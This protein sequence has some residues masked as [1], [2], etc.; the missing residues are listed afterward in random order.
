V[1]TV[2]SDGTLAQLTLRRLVGSTADGQV[3]AGELSMPEGFQLPVQAAV[4]PPRAA[5]RP[6]ALGRF[7]Q[8]ARS[9]AALG[10]LAHPSFVNVFRAGDHL[11]VASEDLP[12]VSLDQVIDR[13]PLRALAEAVARVADGLVGAWGGARGGLRLV[14]GSLVASA[15]QLTP[16]GD[17]RLPRFGLSRAL[18]APLGEPGTAWDAF[19][20]ERFLRD[21]CSRAGDV[22][23]LGALLFAAIAGRPVFAGMAFEDLY[24]MMGDAP[25]VEA[26]IAL[27]LELLPPGTSP[28][29]V[30]L[31]SRALA[32][33]PGLRPE[34]DE[35]ATELRRIDPALPGERL[36]PWCRAQVPEVGPS[37]DEAWQPETWAVAPLQMGADLPFPTLAPTPSSQVP[38]V[39]GAGSPA[40]RSAPPA[41]LGDADRPERI[42]APA[43]PES[44]YPAAPPMAAAVPS[45]GAARTPWA[46]PDEPPSL[47]PAL[48]EPP[49]PPRARFPSASSR[50]LSR[51]PRPA[52]EAPAAELSIAQLPTRVP[53]ASPRI[54][55]P[56]LPGE[57]ADG[58]A[59]D[60]GWI[61][62]VAPLDAQLQSGWQHTMTPAPARDRTEPPGAE[63][64]APLVGLGAAVAATEVDARSARLVV[65]GSWLTV[66]FVALAAGTVLAQAWFGAGGPEAPKLERVIPAPGQRP[67]LVAPAT[68]LAPAA[69]TAPPASPEDLAAAEAAAAEG[70]TLVDR[71]P[72]AGEQAFRRAVERVPAHPDANYGLGYALIRL[73]KV[74]AARPYL[75]AAGLSGDV[76]LRREVASLLQTHGLVCR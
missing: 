3:Y 53:D 48:L 18:A 44:V 16:D 10:A 24:P 70:W 35:F 30:R 47:A 8:E 4:L 34:T 12:G 61:S 54:A 11:V 27:Q 23:A 22:Y 62:G 66:G 59:V 7:A 2:T 43:L 67:P 1:S 41:F 26:W 5:H 25:G 33:E 63:E 19:A 60:R 15:I 28:D 73:D 75:C 39:P 42:S 17:V 64:E 13:I 9:L 55:P 56:S 72:R 58:R 20:P 29:L 38:S 57:G 50:G 14:H 31:L 40:E 37:V 36:G 32:F 52:S 45:F 74:Q 49:E 65:L 76:D 6:A 51:P 21:D 68:A 69:E 46:S 71:D